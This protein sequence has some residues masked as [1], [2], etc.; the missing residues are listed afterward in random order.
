MLVLIVAPMALPGD[1][2]SGGAGREFDA[3][4][5]VAVTAGVLSLVYALTEKSW[6]AGVAAAVLLVGFVLVERRQRLPLVP[7]RVSGRA[8]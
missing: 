1:G 2:R 5:A 6:P 8:L 3:V 7:L 4:G